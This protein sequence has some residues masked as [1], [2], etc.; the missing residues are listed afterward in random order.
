MC[1]AN[2][3]VTTFADIVYSLY[4]KIAYP[5]GFLFGLGVRLDFLVSFVKWKLMSVIHCLVYMA[6]PV[7]T[8]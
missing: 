4:S 2:V 1:V 8:I 7:K 3:N 5:F 6:R